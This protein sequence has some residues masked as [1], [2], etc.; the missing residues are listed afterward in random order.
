VSGKHFVNIFLALS[1][2]VVANMQ[3][4]VFSQQQD[5][6]VV[7]QLDRLDMKVYRQ[8][9]EG[10]VFFRLEQLE[11]KVFGS[12]KKG[13]VFPRLNALN[14]AVNSKQA[15]LD[16]NYSQPPLQ[17][18][19]PDNQIQNKQ[20]APVKHLPD[21]QIPKSRPNIQRDDGYIPGLMEDNFQGKLD[22]PAEDAGDNY[23]AKENKEKNTKKKNKKNLQQ[24]EPPQEDPEFDPDAPDYYDAIQ[25]VNEN[26]VVRFKEM[27]VK[28]YLPVGENITYRD[29]YR[30]AAIRAF[31]IWKLKSN[32]KIDYVLVDNP[33]KSDIVVMWQD[34]FPETG[35]AIGNT[36]TSSG[37]NVQRNA[38]GN[39]IASTG[40]FMPGYYGYGASL[41]GALVG[42]LGNTKKIRDVKLRIGTMPAMKL[43]DEQALNLI[44]S[45][46]SHEF[47]HAIGITAHSTNPNDIMYYE[48]PTDGVFAKIPTLRDID[49]VIKLYNQKPDI[50]D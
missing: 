32:G 43:Q 4:P 20:S 2:A 7:A 3:L 44:E 24:S 13:P 37:Y 36:S 35:N 50:T 33:K 41:L 38:A 48:L 11:E 1:I 29:L 18:M 15:A 34:H 12:A 23:V 5:N 28:V 10:A 8:L 25:Y 30:Q 39:V 19:Q 45:I 40:Y 47:G 42:G 27:P 14:Q 17:Q 22:S 21:L 46:A 16:S 26:K 6:S 9:Q 49:T 31:D